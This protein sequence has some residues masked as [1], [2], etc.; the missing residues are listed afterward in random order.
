MKIER[1]NGSGNL[2]GNGTHHRRA[3]SP[4]SLLKVFEQIQADYAAAL[5]SRFRR[6]RAKLGGTADAHYVNPQ[7]FYQ[8]REYARD[9]ER[10]DAVF[11]Q[12]VGRA[13]NNILRLQFTPDTGEEG[14]N[15]EIKGR[16]DD[17]ADDAYQC[18]QSAKFAFDDIWQ[19]NWLRE[20]IDGDFFMLPLENG[21]LQ[22][23]EGDAVDSPM[24][25]TGGVIHGVRID[26]FGRPVE[27][28]F[29]KQDP[30]RRFLTGR[31]TTAAA[32]YEKRPARDENGEPIVIHS[33]APFRSTQ[34]R[35]VTV[36]HAVFDLA[37][38]LE[39]VNFAQV[40]KQQMA[41]LIMGFLEKTADFKLGSRTTETQDDSTTQT[42][43]EMSP[44]MLLR[45]RKGEKL[46]AFAPSI[47]TSE[48]FEHVRYITRL[49]GLSIG[50]PLS[51]AMLDTEKTTFHGYRGELHEA[52]LGFQVQRDRQIRTVGRPVARWKIREWLASGE[53]GEAAKKL[54]PRIFRHKWTGKGWP[55]VEPFTDAQADKVR[56]DNLLVS[57]RDL[58]AEHGYSW[59]DIVRESTE[60]RKIMIAAAKEVAAELN[61]DIP[62]GEAKI[63]W[64][65]VLNFSPPTNAQAA[66]GQPTKSPPPEKPAAPVEK[67]AQ[68]DP[69]VKAAE[70]R[71]I[72]AESE[73]RVLGVLAVQAK[74]AAVPAP[75]PVQSGPLVAISAPG[76]T[77]PMP[78]GANVQAS[79]EEMKVIEAEQK[80][81]EFKPTIEA[82]LEVP[83]DAIRVESQVK[84]EVTAKVELPPS[85]PRTSV[86]KEADGTETTIV[87]S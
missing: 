87:T 34:S 64:R 11:G 33:F 78:V 61:A 72:V 10:N 22:L 39:D 7:H 44:G 6:T 86:I 21:R 55:Y 26:A 66:L 43:E 19:L 16:F 46:T 1:F 52:R 83:K 41:S 32:E 79:V 35:G 57:P 50:M 30:R 24:D 47:P 77:I 73:A 31:F 53:L 49:I 36:F 84:S 58:A 70:V 51:L 54:G 42:I 18:D 25:L 37:G 38:M 29:P 13:G 71:A 27:Y 40:V 8:M 48:Y 75:T 9:M 2:N 82:R 3:A 68:E 60:D 59:P 12:L 45:G 85:R 5:P 23:V 65:E 69:E 67:K 74:V 17:W 63:T 80:T 20:C 76:A 81:I 62:E 14:L 28:W 15:D 4:Q 56:L